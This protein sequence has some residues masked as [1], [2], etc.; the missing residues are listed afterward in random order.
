MDSYCYSVPVSAYQYLSIMLRLDNLDDIM[1]SNDKDVVSELE[2]AVKK[3]LT[4]W[5]FVNIGYAESEYRDSFWACL[6]LRSILFFLVQP[7]ETKLHPD[8][9]NEILLQFIFKTQEHADH[10]Q[11]W[12]TLKYG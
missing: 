5:S 1:S 6:T 10:F 3:V 9:E 11:M 2:R 8:K 7:H 4:D 12:V